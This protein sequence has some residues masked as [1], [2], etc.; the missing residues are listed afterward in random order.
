MRIPIEDEMTINKKEIERQMHFLSESRIWNT[1]A[2]YVR[3]K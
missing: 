3:K 2:I 1:L